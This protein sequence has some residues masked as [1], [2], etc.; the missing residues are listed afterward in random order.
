MLALAKALELWKIRLEGSKV[1]FYCDNTAVFS[2]IWKG[3][4]RGRL[5]LAL[6]KVLLLAARLDILFDPFWLSSSDN[7]FADTLSCFDLITVAKYNTQC[8]PNHQTTLPL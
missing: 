1:N 7:F 6:R 8:M 3:T 4:T 5:M 2:A